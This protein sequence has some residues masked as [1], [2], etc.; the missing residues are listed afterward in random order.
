[1]EVQGETGAPVPVPRSG[2]GLARFHRI[3]EADDWVI[4]L[5]KFD[6]SDEGEHRACDDRNYEV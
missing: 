6:G 3:A 1:M 2:P 4:G 5:C